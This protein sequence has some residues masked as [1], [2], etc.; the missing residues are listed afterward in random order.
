VIV[1]CKAC[2]GEGRH[3]HDLS[4]DAEP[5]NAEVKT[6][7]ACKIC[8]G[9]GKVQVMCET[10]KGAK[11]ITK[12][13]FKPIIKSAD[14]CKVCGGLGWLDK[15]H[16]QRQNFHKRFNPVMTENLAA[17]IKWKSVKKA[18]KKSSKK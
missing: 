15:N 9:T 12:S 4:G 13:R 11:T 7:V 8:G 3:H 18:S 16:P 17:A 2:R 14:K 1:S 6:D 5:D 10:C